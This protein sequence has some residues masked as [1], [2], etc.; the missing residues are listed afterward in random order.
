M[1]RLVI[2]STDDEVEEAAPGPITA[3]CTQGT[4]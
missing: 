1:P 4:D 2:E 3:L